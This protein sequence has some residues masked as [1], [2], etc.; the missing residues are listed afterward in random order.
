MLIEFHVENH[1]SLRDEQVLTMTAGRV[2]DDADTRPRHVDGLSETLLPVAALYGSNASGKTNVLNALDFMRAA[3]LFSF[4]NWEPDQ[5]V[6]RNQF[7]WGP[8]RIEPSFF[9]VTVLVDTVRYQY[10]FWVSDECILEEWLFAWPNGKKQLW[11]ER[12]GGTYKF[13]DNLKGDNKLIE[14]VTRTNALFLSTAVQFKHPQLQ[15]I[16]SW[17]RAMRPLNVGEFSHMLST[18]LAIAR[19]FEEPGQQTLFPEDDASRDP[20]S[21]RFLALLRSADLG[22]VNL[23]VEKSEPIERSRRPLRQ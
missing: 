10:G 2:G 22:I 19:L 9:E 12:D 3:V 8:R 13:G 4:N 7:A 20:L 21:E 14:G 6:P 23:R 11:F 5:G 1:R 18:E 15:A 16:F 17:F